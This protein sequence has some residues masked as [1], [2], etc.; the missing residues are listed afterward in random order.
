MYSNTPV[1]NLKLMFDSANG[2]TPA[3]KECAFAIA[4]K[5][6]QELIEKTRALQTENQ[7]LQNHVT[8]L[9]IDNMML[10]QE[11]ATLTQDVYRYRNMCGD[12]AGDNARIQ[13]LLRN[14]HKNKK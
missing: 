1:T 4:E 6:E 8:A 12:L 5:Q 3:G 7:R 9:E 10:M 2:Q 13:Q 14:A 11:N